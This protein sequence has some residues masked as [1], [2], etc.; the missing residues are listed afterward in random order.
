MELIFPIAVSLLLFVGVL[1]AFVPGLPVIFCMFLVSV[2]FGIVDDFT[3]LSAKELVA[4]GVVYLVSLLVDL[5]S[6]ALAARYGGA[7]LR[8]VFYGICGLVLGFLV[9]PP[10]GG[11]MGLCL[12]ILGSELFREHKTPARALKSTAFAFLGVLGG[13]AI[14]ILLALLFAA[15]FL[16]FVFFV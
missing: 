9:L 5:F 1:V 3:R 14:N 16:V 4:L 15:L 8:S 13:A 2:L 6:G 11:I 10:F 7:S 12:G